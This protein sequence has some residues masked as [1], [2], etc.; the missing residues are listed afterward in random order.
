M[1]VFRLDRPH[2]GHFCKSVEK[3]FLV[4][5]GGECKRRHWVLVEGEGLPIIL[6]FFSYQHLQ[7]VFF[8]LAPSALAF[9]S[10]D[11]QLNILFFSTPVISYCLTI[12]KTVRFDSK[13][14][15]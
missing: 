5:G 6:A 15:I 7:L 2:L 12:K 13:T 3:I 4:F 8:W 1:H 11:N 14:L 9:I 10:F